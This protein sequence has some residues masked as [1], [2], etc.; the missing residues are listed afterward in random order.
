[1]KKCSKC[2]NEYTL[3]GFHK[4]K[5][6]SPKGVCKLCIKEYNKYYRENNKEKVKQ[7]KREWDENNK[8][9]IRETAKK[10]YADNK[11]KVNDNIKQWRKDNPERYK[12][13]TK[14]R[15]KRRMETDPLYKFKRNV[16]AAIYKP[17]KRNGFK[18]NSKSHD[19]LGCSYEE[20]KI[21][22]ESL[23]EDWM[24]WD[25]YA[26]FDGSEKS[27]WDIDHIIPISEGTTKEEILKLNHYTNLQPLCSY[28][29]RYI[30]LDNII[31]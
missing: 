20:F 27:G 18:K 13:A 29:N 23:W 15:Y 30:K 5:D 14:E 12:K 31:E 24:N 28:Y 22:I 11:E 1:M 16:R 2:N 17:L 6:G 21:H 9:K 25:N 26:T 10:Y 8:E 19:I 3:E 7:L 4:R